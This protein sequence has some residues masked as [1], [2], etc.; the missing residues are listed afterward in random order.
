MEWKNNLDV[1]D[2]R[3]DAIDKEFNSIHRGIDS[4]DKIA[5]EAYNKIAILEDSI[6]G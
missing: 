2:R 4:A 1:F 3:F 6:K 5:H